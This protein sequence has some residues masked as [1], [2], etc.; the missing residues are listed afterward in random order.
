MSEPRLPD[1]ARSFERHLRSENKSDRTVET[2]L[3]APL[4]LPQGGSA[5]SN[6]VGATQRTTA[7]RPLTWT[8][9]GQRPCCVSDG[10]RPGP[11]VGEHLC[12]IRARVLVRDDG[13]TAVHTFVLAACHRP[14]A[15]RLVFSVGGSSQRG[16]ADARGRSLASLCLRALLRAS[17]WQPTAVRNCVFPR[18]RWT[19]RGEVRRSDGW[20][21]RHR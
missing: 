17:K 1:L 10:A 6:P 14:S 21:H 2:Y 19:V 12:P 9:E 15:A 18:S 5:G 8:N 20:G 13:F 4:P 16:S 7:T 11:A 3:E